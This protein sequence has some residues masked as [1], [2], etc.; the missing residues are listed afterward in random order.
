MTNVNETV[1]SYLAAWNE[2]DPKRRREFVAAAW[3]EEGSYID[4]HRHGHGHN[5]IDAMLA[6]TQPQFPNHRLMP[7]QRHRGAQQFC[8]LLLGRRRHRRSAA[9]YRRHRFRNARAGRPDE[10]GRRLH[11]RIA[12]DVRTKARVNA[13]GTART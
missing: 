6:A 8:A 4:A 1:V 3:T 7:S 2:R 11:G 12:G 10:D 13:D 9:L 5:A